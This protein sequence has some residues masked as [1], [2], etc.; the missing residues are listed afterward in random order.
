MDTAQFRLNFPLFV[1]TVKYPNDMVAFW[2]TI[3]ESNVAI[4]K[5][6]DIRNQAVELYTAHHLILASDSD[7]GK[8]TGLLN[9]KSIGDVSVG[10]DTGSTSELNAGHWNTTTYGKM[11]I[12]LA[13]MYGAGCIQL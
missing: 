6:G 13:R 7:I 11:F 5:W 12:R 4:D 3:A 9:S 1:D 10:Y 8:Q 2:S